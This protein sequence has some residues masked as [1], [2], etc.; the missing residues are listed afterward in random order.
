M[1]LV[2]RLTTNSIP[3][4]MG[5]PARNEIPKAPILAYLIAWS[6]GL[7][8][9][10][11]YIMW[12]YIARICIMKLYDSCPFTST[13]YS[14]AMPPGRHNSSCAVTDTFGA[15]LECLY[16]VAA[17]GLVPWLL[18]RPSGRGPSALAPLGHWEWKYTACFMHAL[19]GVI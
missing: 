15:V 12:G 14:F 1:K 17:H 6:I 10:G 8:G 19:E 2:T 9:N 3:V 7:F 16:S 4:M 13:G 11:P 18:A 5:R